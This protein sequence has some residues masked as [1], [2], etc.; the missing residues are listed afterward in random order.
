MPVNVM[1]TLRKAVRE[2]ETEKA[3]LDRQ[4]AALR[5]VRGRMESS[6]TAPVGR[7]DRREP[8]GADD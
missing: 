1:A 4:L 5:G 6:T 7:Q 8:D 3:R 2:L